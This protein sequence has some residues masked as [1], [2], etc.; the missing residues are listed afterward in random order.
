[1]NITYLIEF[2]FWLSLIFLV[3]PFVAPE[4]W[5]VSDA[6]KMRARSLGYSTWERHYTGDR[7]KFMVTYRVVFFILGLSLLPT[8][9]YI[10][11]CAS[12]GYILNYYTEYLALLPSLVFTQEARIWQIILAENALALLYLAVGVVW[13]VGFFAIY[14]R[15]LGRQ[16]MSLSAQWL[17]SKGLSEIPNG[18]TSELRED[19]LLHTIAPVR[20]QMLYTGNF[21]LEALDQ[22]RFFVANVLIWPVS[23]LSYLIGDAV[24]VVSEKV[25]KWL[26]RRLDR[27]WKKYMPEVA[28]D[29][30]A[31]MDFQEKISAVVLAKM[32]T[33]CHDE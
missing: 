31:A 18:M 2:C 16:Y 20:D 11:L 30:A 23:I 17:K 1:M 19:Y 29:Y 14:A 21:P 24:L 15:R 12:K 10:Y 13:A 25:D 7:S 28:A 9:P 8:L 4:S 6:L 27:K 3:I 26:M 5:L 33:G 22:K 32:T